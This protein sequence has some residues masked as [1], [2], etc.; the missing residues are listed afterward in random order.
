MNYYKNLY[1]QSVAD[2]ETHNARSDII[3]NY[4]E[5]C[6]KEYDKIANHL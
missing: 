4:G 5:H 1:L 2:G 3:T 6:R